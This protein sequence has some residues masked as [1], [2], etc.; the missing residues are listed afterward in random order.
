MLYAVMQ[1]GWKIMTRMGRVTKF[2]NSQK[3]PPNIWPMDVKH[4]DL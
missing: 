1:G 3:C 4:T 2:N